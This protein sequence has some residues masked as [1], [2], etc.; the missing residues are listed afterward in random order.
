VFVLELFNDAS[1]GG[2]ETLDGVECDEK[3]RS[4]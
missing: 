2:I 4:N 1:A 3:A